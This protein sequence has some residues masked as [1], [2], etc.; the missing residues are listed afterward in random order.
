M[1]V[2]TTP[3]RWKAMFQMAKHTAL[4]NT[5]RNSQ[6]SRTLVWVNRG[7]RSG[8][9]SV[10]SISGTAVM[11]AH[12]MTRRVTRKLSYCSVYFLIRMEYTA[13][14]RAAARAIRSPR[15]FRWKVSWPLSTTSTTPAMAMTA[16]MYTNLPRRS[17][18]RENSWAKMTVRMGDRAMMM[19]TLAAKV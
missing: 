7:C 8:I 3:S 5:P 15:G 14:M 6:L 16:P 9:P 18:L 11:K 2:M 12:S 13:H 19:L 10:S 1:L 17:P 4:P